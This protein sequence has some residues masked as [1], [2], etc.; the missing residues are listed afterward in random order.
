MRQEFIEEKQRVNYNNPQKFWR[1]IKSVVPAKKQQIKTISLRD[2]GNQ[3][4]IG[5]TADCVNTFFRG[6]WARPPWQRQGA[7]VLGG[8]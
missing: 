6:Y 7:L 8:A 2:E 4:S 5:D 3:I 1:N